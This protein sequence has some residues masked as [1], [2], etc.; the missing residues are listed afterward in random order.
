M[1]SL[2]AAAVAVRAEGAKGV[3]DQHSE[4]V[5]AGIRSL[6]LRR[7]LL[8]KAAAA[9][10]DLCRLLTAEISPAQRRSPPG[11]R[12]GCPSV[13]RSPCRMVPLLKHKKNL[14]NHILLP[15]FNGSWQKDALA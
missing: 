11:Y 3:I 15:N 2:E 13:H 6:V 9:K 8:A 10:A 12:G 4:V 7:T 14:D 5:A 1:H